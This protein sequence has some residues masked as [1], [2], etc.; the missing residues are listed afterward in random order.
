MEL[1]KQLSLYS[2]TLIVIGSCIGVG[3]FKTPSE[4]A[5][6]LPS[7][8]WIM[9]AWGVGGLIAVSGALTY[10]ELGGMFP[11]AGGQY[12]FLKHAYNDLIAFLFGWASLTVVVTGAIAAICLIFSSYINEIVFIG[13]NGKTI[14][15]VFTIVILSVVHILGIRFGDIFASFITIFKLLGIFAI[16]IFALYLGNSEIN[17]FDFSSHFLE[18]NSESKGFTSAFGLA[19]IGVVFSVGGFNHASFLASET[20][21]AKR[22]VPLAMILGTLIVSLVYLLVNLALLYLLPVSKI[23]SSESVVSDA[24][25]SIWESGALL[26]ALLIAISALGTAGIYMM[27]APR[28]YFAMAKDGLFFKKLASIHPKF[29]TPVLAI[30]I[31]SSWTIILLLFWGTFSRII[32][33]VTFVDWVF[34]LLTGLAIF[35]LRKRKPNLERPYKTWAY[36]ITPLIFVGI[37]LF[38]LINTLINKPEEALAGVLFLVLGMIAFL[39]FQRNG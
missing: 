30:V 10:S 2:L 6:Y 14:L 9:I 1:K 8:S 37:G 32:I 7:A 28:V 18:N 21:N 5:S 31:Q 39:F 4:I 23:V 33:F 35:I 3:I 26:I 12:L 17:S 11:K 38:I 15:S 20:K 36:P 29:K 19:L 13:E 24:V 22:N 27:T 34:H 25:K 16:V